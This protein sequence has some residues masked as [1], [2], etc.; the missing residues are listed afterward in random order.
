MK[1]CFRVR[2][3]RDVLSGTVRAALAGNGADRTNRP[4]MQAAG[5]LAG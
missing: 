1:R 2:G 5:T 3:R 4:R